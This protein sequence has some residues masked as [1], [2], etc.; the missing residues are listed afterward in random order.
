MNYSKYLRA[1]VLASAALIVAVPGCA[2]DGHKRSTGQYTDDV[3]T[4][5]RVREALI[6]AP[7]LRSNTIQVETY[8]G[9][10]QLS[11]FAD[12]Q[13]SINTAVRTTRDVS[14]VKEVR[15]DIRLRRP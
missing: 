5:T 4:S 8:Q 14:G 11:G 12:N 10:V 13:E 3:A 6:R 7:G 15:N 1:A 2:S 9:V